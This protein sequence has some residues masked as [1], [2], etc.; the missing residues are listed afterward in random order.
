MANTDRP[1]GFRFAKSLTGHS[2]NAMARPYAVTSN[3]TRN[4]LTD[5]NIY[6]GDAVT[7][8]ASGVMLPFTTND[9]ALGVV[10]GISGPNTSVEHGAIGPFNPDNLEDRVLLEAEAGTV[11]VV[12]AEGNIFEVQTAAVLTLLPGQLADVSPDAGSTH[13]ST[14]TSR[15]IMEIITSTNGDVRVVEQVTTPD[16][17]TT[18]TNARYLVQFTDIVNS[19]T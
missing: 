14:T 3:A 4:A 9:Q 8:N 18:L 16:N 1:N 10:V 6:L 5:G 17:D 7:L 13:G 15:S 11:W 12:P 19:Q 2:L